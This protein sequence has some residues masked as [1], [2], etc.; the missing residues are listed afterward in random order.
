MGEE[1]GLGKKKVAFEGAK[2]RDEF[3]VFK[4]EL[5]EGLVRV[6]VCVFEECIESLNG[7]SSSQGTSGSRTSHRSLKTC[8]HSGI[9]GSRFHIHV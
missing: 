5:E 6:C 4:E 2:T 3:L 9:D 1:E 7:V 8:H